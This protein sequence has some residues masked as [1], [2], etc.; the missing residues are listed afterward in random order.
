LFEIP[1]GLH[2]WLKN[3]DLAIIS[4]HYVPVNRLSGA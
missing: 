2:K 4:D 3:I 1:T